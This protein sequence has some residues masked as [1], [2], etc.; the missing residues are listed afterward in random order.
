M[1]K[2]NY[3]HARKQ[4][5]LARKARQLEKQQRRVTRPTAAGEDTTVTPTD[6]PAVAVNPVSENGA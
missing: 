6:T 4:K 2:P 5:E 1:P 3:H